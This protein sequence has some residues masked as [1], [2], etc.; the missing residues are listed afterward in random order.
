MAAAKSTGGVTLPKQIHGR[1]LTW[2]VRRRKGLTLNGDLLDG[3]CVP[4]R[5]EI[6]INTD[7]LTMPDR[8]RKALLHE[9]M[10]AMLEAHPQYHDE[11]LIVLLE[12]SVDELIRLN[13]DFL[14]MYG[15]A[16]KS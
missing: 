6:V 8:A 1:G 5:Q 14:A 12:E 3:L 16:P 7:I 15:Y 2:R 4:I 10:H 13:P 9:A 11:S